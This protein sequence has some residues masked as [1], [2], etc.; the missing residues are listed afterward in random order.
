MPYLYLDREQAASIFIAALARL[1][2]RSTL[3]LF[4]VVAALSACD[5]PTQPLRDARGLLL[6]VRGT[7]RAAEIVVMRPDGSERRQ[8]TDNAVMDVAPAWSPDGRRIVFVRAQDSIAGYP[9]RRPDIYVMNAD[10]SGA[11]RL[12][13]SSVAAGAPQWSPDG[14][15][16]IFEQPDPAS[17]G[18]QLYVMNVD[19]SNVRRLSS[20]PPENFGADWSH[21][22]ARVLF[23]SNRSPRYWW[24]MYVMNA[25]GSGERQLA[26]DEACVSN[27]S[28]ARWSPDDAVIAYS[29]DADYSGALWIIGADGTNPVR[30]TT[31]GAEPV[32]SPD[33]KQ[34]AFVST[35]DGPY[36]LYIL[37]RPSGAVTRLTGDTVPTIP[38]SWGGGQ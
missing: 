19:G 4:A 3:C 37:E 30:L 36:S 20:G 12:F 1:A 2:R 26:G 27:A 16:I 21:D 24:T 7:G 29:C 33:G 9:Q 38:S 22:G 23:L 17:G 35:R 5:S 10:G 31:P 28:G 14:Q 11:R 25:D 18:F 34:I 15:R 6:V 13:E 8:L 32:W